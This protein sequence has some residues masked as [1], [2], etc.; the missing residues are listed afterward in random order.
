M[1]KILLSWNGLNIYSYPAMLYLGVM[2]GVFAGAHVAQLS[3]M[4]PNSFAVAIVFLMVPA[5]IGARLLFVAS[6]WD[7]FRRDV[8]RIWRRSEGG[9]AM[10]GGLI[11]TVPLSIPLLRA[12]HLPFAEFWDAATVTILLGMVFTRVGCLLNGCCAG[13]PTS[14]WLGLESAGPS[15]GLAAADPSQ[16]LEMLWATILLTAAVALRDRAPFPGA[17]IC[18]A[19]VAYAAGRLMLEPLRDDAGSRGSAAMQ[20]TS[21]LL[22]VAALIAIMIAWSA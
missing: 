16:L 7:M 2:A 20:A 21:I 4:N 17:I 22:I 6:H 13:R 18:S 19:I 1:R 15:R 11:V 8:S 12:M 10:Y 9:M 5:L 14:S 3:G